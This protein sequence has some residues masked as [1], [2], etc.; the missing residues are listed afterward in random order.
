VD[1]GALGAFS[2]LNRRRDELQG[3]GSLAWALDP[4]VHA[5]DDR[6]IMENVAAVR[7]QLAT[8]AAIAPGA[9]RH[10]AVDL[11]RGRDDARRG[12]SFEAA[13]LV[14][15][16]AHAAGGVT[17]ISVPAPAGM[18]AEVVA[19]MGG[20]EGI[21]AVVLA[22]PRR[23]VAGLGVRTADAVELL[24]ANLTARRIGVPVA[25][26]RHVLGPYEVRSVTASA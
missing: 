25:G 8:A 9:E 3:A 21:P 17:T 16:V 11:A 12:T 26:R 22:D 18:T 10:L 7:D 4:Q 23:R 19:R 1:A 14:A 15:A 13:W 5:T 6:S 2:E 24:L 20:W